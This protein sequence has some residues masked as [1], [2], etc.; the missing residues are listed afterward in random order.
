MKEVK[1]EKRLCYECKKQIKLEEFSNS[2]SGKWGKS[3]ICKKCDLSKKK[4]K[5]D[6]I[7]YSN[8]YMPI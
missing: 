4:I 5:R 8:F 1:P 6:E 2:S 3:N 7:D